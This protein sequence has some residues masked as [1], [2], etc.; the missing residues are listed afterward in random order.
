MPSIRFVA[1]VPHSAA[2]SRSQYQAQSFECSTLGGW[3]ATRSGGHF[4]TLYTHI[5]DLVELLRVITR[6]G[7]IETRQLSSG[8]GGRAGGET[9]TVGIN[10]AVDAR[11]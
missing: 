9:L 1:V 4:A 10:A 2:I 11:R 5:D 7:V 6:K 3:I 8:A